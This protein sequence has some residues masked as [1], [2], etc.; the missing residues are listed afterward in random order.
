MTLEKFIKTHIY[1]SANCVEYI[2]TNGMEIVCNEEDLLSY[3]V[4]DCFQGSG[5]YLEITVNNT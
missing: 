1:L 3:N 4:V 5:G 2:D